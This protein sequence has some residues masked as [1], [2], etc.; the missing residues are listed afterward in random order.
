MS[1]GAMNI[2]EAIVP[3]RYQALFDEM[4]A[5]HGAPPPRE[6]VTWGS[7]RNYPSS[8][9]FPKPSE[10]SDEAKRICK[11]D[12]AVYQEC[13]EWIMAAPPST[14]G[15]WGGMSQRERHEILWPH[16]AIARAER[17]E[18][19]E[20][21]AARR[22]AALEQRARDK[23]KRKEEQ[24]RER[25][26][27]AND[28][29]AQ[30]RLVAAA[31]ARE[32]YNRQRLTRT[33]TYKPEVKLTSSSRDPKR[34]N[35]GRVVFFEAGFRGPNPRWIKCRSDNPMDALEKLRMQVA[36]LHPQFLPMVLAKVAEV[37]AQL[38][39]DEPASAR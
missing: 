2:G 23:L 3:G 11:E 6:V 10:K 19:E 12:C 24:E 5:A 28:L 20:A 7:C 9:F 4:Q 26:A 18:R 37:T 29:A 36:I 25:A 17:M 15:I 30:K 35:A 32:R 31:K 22:R 38:G 8:M 34:A 1:I 13:H 27:K 14:A 16:R 33:R 39:V 21:A